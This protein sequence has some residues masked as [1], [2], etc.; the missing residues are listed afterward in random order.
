[1]EENSLRHC[2][3]FSAEAIRLKQE[4]RD[5]HVPLGLAMTKRNEIM[6]TETFF[7]HFAFVLET[8]DGVKK[9]R[10]LI[11]SLAMKGKL[12]KQ[13][14]K[15]QPAR[16]LLKEI[17]FAKER[18]VKEGK[19]RAQKS[20]Q[21]VKPEEMPYPV[22]DGWE[23]VRFGDVGI[24]GSSSRVHQKDWTNKGIPFFRA[25]EIV[26]LSKYGTV[27]NDLFITEELFQSLS[28]SG[29]TPESGDL[30][31]TGV[32]TIGIPYIVKQSDKF[33]FKDASVLIFK[34][35]FKLFPQ[36]ISH[37]LQSPY[38][39]DEIHSKSMGTTVHTLTIIRANEIPFPLPPIA[40][41]KRIVAKIDQ[42]MAICDKLEIERN[43]KSDKRI[44]I[45]TA[46]INK[47]I[48]ATDKSTFNSSWNFITKN[49]SE[50]YS[51]PENVEELKKNILQLAVMGKL[52]TQDPKNQ[53]ASELLKEIE[54]EKKGLVKDGTIR[55]QDQLSPIKPEEIPF[56]VP[57][58][59][60][61]CRIR[62]I[63]H[64]W[65]QKTPDKKFT[66]IDVGAIDNTKGVITSNVQLLDS[67]E[68]PS[69]ARKIVKSGTVIY[70]T[71]RPYLL[72][73]AIL[74][75]D[76][77][78]EPIASTAFAILH[79]FNGI[80]NRYL[81]Y[82]LHSTSFIE[83]VNIKMKGVAYPAINDGNFYQ[84]PF[85]LPP[86]AEQKR[87]VAKIDQLMSLCNNLQ[88]EIKNSTSKQTAILDAVLAKL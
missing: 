72:N 54:E 56:E 79:P 61:W 49:F 87:I 41:Q 26:K 59:W 11:L 64:D 17:H 44:K 13:N 7:K 83:Y 46:A 51:V 1:L 75:E 2:E 69:R 70:S 58:G 9:L 73:I 47:L 82:Y 15:D 36:F 39:I 18:L 20:L 29:I 23:W 52:V 24:I 45:H 19:I 84:G 35:C 65:G 30:M 50:L 5:R 53:P 43:E 25:R 16:E 31:V 14:P 38:C 86:F 76:Y 85:P 78:N 63:C 55:K 4:K 60:E 27:E 37:F 66:Y 57:K 32:G 62:E 6:N 68:A 34:N 21:L 88:Q 10:E 71:V 67:S 8:P 40:E 48:S 77:K 3:A 12:V 22:P 74:E 42:L 81:Y 33:Y 28:K 80:Y